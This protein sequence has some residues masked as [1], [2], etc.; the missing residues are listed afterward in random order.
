MNTN[1]QE[2][3]QIK[4]YSKFKKNIHIKSR[5][6]FKDNGNALYHD[7]VDSQSYFLLK[8]DL[9]LYLF[10]DIHFNDIDYQDNFSQ[11][12]KLRKSWLKGKMK[13]ERLTSDEQ[14]LLEK[15]FPK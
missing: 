14:L 2:S 7:E 1:I 13:Y 3:M 15:L 9:S 12:W 11:Y 10:C 6:Y 4:M 5:L 8:K